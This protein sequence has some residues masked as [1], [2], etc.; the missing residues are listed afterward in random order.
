MIEQPT[1]AFEINLDKIEEGFLYDTMMCYAENL[2]QVLY[3]FRLLRP[4]IASNSLKHKRNHILAFRLNPLSC[5]RPMCDRVR[6]VNQ[7][8]KLE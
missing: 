7:L 5:S 3:L 4:E 6:V 8:E 1:K 2:L